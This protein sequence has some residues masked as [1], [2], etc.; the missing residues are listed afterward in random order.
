MWTYIMK[1]DFRT[2]SRVLCRE[3]VHISEF[4][5]IEVSMYC[6][7][8]TSKRIMPFEPGSEGHSELSQNIVYTAI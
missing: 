2:S 6:A 1:K 7:L 4:P 5:L 8:S 3:A